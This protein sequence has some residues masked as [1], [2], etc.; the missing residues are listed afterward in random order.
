[1]TS[2]T[3][4][5]FLLADLVGFTEDH[6]D[7]AAADLGGDWIRARDSLRPSCRTR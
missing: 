5:T 2:G 4:T 1:V 3:E 7:A 6:G